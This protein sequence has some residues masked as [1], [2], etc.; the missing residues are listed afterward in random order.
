MDAVHERRKESLGNFP[1][2]ESC[3]EA[4]KADHLLQKL[5]KIRKI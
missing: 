1:H 2:Q 3:V 5:K 4:G